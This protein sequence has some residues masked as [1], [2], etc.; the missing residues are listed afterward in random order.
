MRITHASKCPCK[1]AKYDLNEYFGTMVLSIQRISKH[2]TDAICTRIA[3]LL[4]LSV[5]MI[6]QC[7][8]LD[9]IYS[10]C[11]EKCGIEIST[12]GLAASSNHRY[13]TYFKYFATNK[14]NYITITVDLLLLLYESC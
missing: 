9:Q 7:C 14:Q 1:K 8:V 3:V 10:N 12:R 11:F 4:Y 5:Y 13:L 2:F 6:E